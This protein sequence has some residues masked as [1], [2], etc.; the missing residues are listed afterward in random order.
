M[1][2]SYFGFHYIALLFQVKALRVPAHREFLFSS[3]A[4]RFC[5]AIYRKLTKNTHFCLQ[6]EPSTLPS[7]PSD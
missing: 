2:P 5:Y 4:Q 3:E 1:P 7:L 6:H